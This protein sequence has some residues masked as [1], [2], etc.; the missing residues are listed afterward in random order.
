MRNPS[1]NTIKKLLRPC[2]NRSAGWGY[3]R[4]NYFLFNKVGA[5]LYIMSKKKICNREPRG[6]LKYIRHINTFQEE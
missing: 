3:A 5:V 6:H 4:S 1:K 2:N